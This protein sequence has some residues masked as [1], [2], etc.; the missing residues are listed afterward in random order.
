MAPEQARGEAVDQRADLFALGSMLYA[1]C[2]GHAPFRGDSAMSVLRQVCDVQPQPIRAIDPEAPAWLDGIIRKLHEKNP[3]ERFQSAAEVSDLLE[4]CLAHVQH[5]DRHPV[6]A[7]AAHLGK[8]ASRT[9]PRRRPHRRPVAT[10]LMVILIGGMGLLSMLWPA[11]PVAHEKQEPSEEISGQASVTLPDEDAGT[12]V[13]ID[14]RQLRSELDGLQRSLV[15]AAEDATD[16]TASQIAGAA[17]RAT[18]LERELIAEGDVGPDLIASQMERIRQRL[19]VL[20]RE[21]GVRPE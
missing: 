15:E 17:R 14:F 8:E 5:P 13:A 16:S 20:A 3:A 12:D 21:L 1:T 7:L 2:T 18:R 9:L 19:Q 6:P 11:R 4:R 10:V